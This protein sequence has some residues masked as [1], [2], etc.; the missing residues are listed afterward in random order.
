MNSELQKWIKIFHSLTFN[1]EDEFKDIYSYENRLKHFKNVFQRKVLRYRNAFLVAYKESKELRTA[2]HEYM[3][4][5]FDYILFVN[6]NV[7]APDQR[8]FDGGG[9]IPFTAYW[10]QVIIWELYNNFTLAYYKSRDI[11]LSFAINAGEAMSLVHN[12]G[13]EVFYLS[14]VQDDVDKSKD[15]TNS[16]MGRVRQI[17]ESTR[18]YTLD[19]FY[20]DVFLTLYSDKK[21]GI[22]GS[23]TNANPNRGK[24]GKRTFADEAGAQK[25]LN[26]VIQSISMSSKFVTYA[27]TL[28]IGTDAAFRDV[29][30]EGHEVN[31]GEL[32]DE[33]R[34]D[35]KN[36]LTYRQAVDNMVNNLRSKIPEGKSLSFHNTFRDHPLKAGNCDYY[37]IECNRLLNDE[38]I[39]A[40]ELE[41]DLNA[42]SPDR[43]FYSLTSEHFRDLDIK[44]FSGY[45]VMM[46]FDPGSHGKA[47]MTPVIQDHYG[48]YYILESEIFNRGSMTQ[49]LDYLTAKYGKFKVFAEQSV[50]A[51]SDAGSGWLSVLRARGVETIIVTNRHMSDQL[52]AINELFRRKN[53]NQYGDLELTVKMSNKNKWYAM[54]YIY[55]EKDKDLNQNSM[56]HPAESLIAVLFQNNRHIL[57]DIERDWIVA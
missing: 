9:Y 18:I 54:S 1:I 30:R 10:Y 44:D 2:Y 14:R 43:S 3:N 29:I 53:T 22:T 5:D 36:G 48:F 4:K 28:L 16:N 7:S 19:N 47:A 32:F 17:I 41:A 8:K 35:I 45:K 13:D 15:R 40:H 50:K 37:D 38:V 11:G 25:N 24:R 33:I 23:S 6:L 31:P 55:G 46:G 57:A 12:R 27:G 42:G 21:T 52:L 56:S 34:T 51:Y 20:H 39:I 49:W 26:Q